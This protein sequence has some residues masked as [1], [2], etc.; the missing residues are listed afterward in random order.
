MKAGRLALVLVMALVSAACGARLTDEQRAAG[1]SSVSAGGSAGGGDLTDQLGDLADGGAV[2]SDVTGSGGSGGSGGTS[3]RSGSSGGGGNAGSS[4]SGGGGGTGGGGGG[5]GF[6]G[7]NGGATDTGVTGDRITIYTLAD[8]TGPRP[9]L[10]KSAHQAVAAF[11][12]YINSQGG[13]YGRALVPKLIDSKTDSG[14]YRA[15]VLEA[16]DNAFALIGSMSAFDDTAKQA[17]E[18]CMIPDIPGPPTAQSHIE[19]A[20]TFPPYPNRG[21]K[22]GTGPP[23][24]TAEKYPNAV[25]K[26]ALLY[27]NAAAGATNAAARK[28][29][30]QRTGF[31]FIH[32]QA[33]QV[34]EP[35]YTPFI[36]QMRDKGVEYVTFV[37]DNDTIAKLMK[38]AHQQG[39]APEVWDW[40]SVAYDPRFPE[41]VTAEAGEGA[42]IFINTQ[43]WEE[44]GSIP[45][46]A[47]YLEWLNRVAPNAQP[48]YF[49]LYAWSAA[50]LFTEAALKTGPKLTRTGMVETL[51]GWG[52]WDGKGIHAPHHIGSK[53]PSKCFMYVRMSGGKFVRDY[54][55]QGLE[56][57]KGRVED[58]S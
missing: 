10:F 50:R 1:I 22:V 16:C 13:I 53:T 18:S 2:G 37:G 34:V 20:S 12:A 26:A 19:A 42:R 45:E 54:P 24:Y 27:I 17:I 25:K 28:A 11:A 55:L 3:G 58:A 21:D 5:S 47:L 6:S 33:V 36:T 49:G 46:M 48:D 57:S 14:A 29:A 23:A 9:G 39:W 52:E 56:C 43:M 35:N 15:G 8:V 44:A 41:K 32:E 4:D 7:D 40:D 38:A 30:W 31:T 51:K